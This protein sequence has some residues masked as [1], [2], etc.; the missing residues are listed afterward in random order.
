MSSNSSPSS[1]TQ[2][3]DLPNWAQPAAWELLDKTRELSK[4]PM[5]VYTEQRSA[6]LNKWQDASQNM[7]LNR[8]LGGSTAMN[9]GNNALYG[10]LNGSNLSGNPHL[11]SQIDQASQ[12]V[13]RNYQGAVGST[14]ATFA[15]SGA[16]G[17]SAWQQAQEGNSRQLAQGLSDM[18]SN[19][20]FQNYAN[21]R[22][23][24]M[25]A[26]G[27]AP[28]YANQAYYDADQLAKA[29]QSRYGYDQQ[30]MDDRRSVWEE[31]MQSPY[32]QLDLLANGIAGAVGNGG[33][34]TSTVPGAN[35]WAQAVGGGAA[36]AGLLGSV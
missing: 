15:R 28:T 9:M 29:G 8:A 10:T 11:Q 2:T 23:N 36:L 19:M 18:T 27:M 32:R 14:D 22:Q 34:M 20:R 3:K 26:L 1:T 33:Q 16:F 25:Q 12:D 31:Q 6:D 4:Q 7:V 35:R 5:P 13:T 21:E 24:Q 17:G 30:R